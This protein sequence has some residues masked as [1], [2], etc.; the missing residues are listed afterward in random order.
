MGGGVHF[1][2]VSIEV[3]C[4]VLVA[5]VEYFLLVSGIEEIAVVF[6]FLVRLFFC[7]LF[8]C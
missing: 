8:R 2:N 7:F 4:F 3:A 6:V 5:G 1:L